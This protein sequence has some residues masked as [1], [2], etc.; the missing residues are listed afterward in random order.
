YAFYELLWNAGLF[1][2]L[3]WLLA[4]N[5]DRRKEKFDLVLLVFLAAMMFLATGMYQVLNIYPLTILYPM[6]REV[7][8]FAP[9][10]VLA[11]LLLIARL[12]EHT[13]WR[14]ALLLVVVGSLL[15]VGVKFEYYS[16]KIDFA[17]IRQQFQPFKQVAD[18]DTGSYRILA[19]PFFDK[20]VLQHSPSDQQD[21]TP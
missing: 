8:H 14:W 16:Q 6:L 19:Y 5:N 11:A 20:Y 21:S 7:G 10:I 18:Q 3:L 9:V 4:R 15:I 13:R 1:V 2:F 17:S 12:V